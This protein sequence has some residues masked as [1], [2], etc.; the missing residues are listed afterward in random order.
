[1]RSGNLFC[2]KDPTVSMIWLVKYSQDN[3]NPT[4]HWNT[5]ISF[6]T[7]QPRWLQSVCARVCT[8]AQVC[9]RV[10]MTVCIKVYVC[11]IHHPIPIVTEI[12]TTI[13][14]FSF[15]GLLTLP[16]HI[17]IIM[18]LALVGTHDRWIGW[19][20]PHWSDAESPTKA[21]H[22]VYTPQPWTWFLKYTLI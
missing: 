8:H 4:W 2:C 6:R 5:W 14:S 18:L 21:A 3:D 9:A 15:C 11:S 7:C 10:C 16:C 19:S 12:K 22:C 20:Q 1:M 17:L 13:F